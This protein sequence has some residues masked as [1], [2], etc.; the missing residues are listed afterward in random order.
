VTK[1]RLVTPIGEAKWVYVFTPKPE[2]EVKKKNGRTFT[3]RS[4]YEITLVFDIADSQWKEWASDIKRRAQAAGTNIPIR[5]ETDK[6]G[7]P[8]GKYQAAF[9]TDPKYKPNVVDVFGQPFEGEFG[10]GSKVRVNFSPS[11]YDMSGGGVTLYLNSVQVVEAVAHQRDDFPVEPKTDP[12]WEP[13][14]PI[15]DDSPDMPF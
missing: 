5:P 7:K 3:K 4:Q 15:P 11:Q 8:T 2:R 10:Y 14:G 1:E 12:E 6:E 9:H 13:A